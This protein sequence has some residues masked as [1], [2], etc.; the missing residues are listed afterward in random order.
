MASANEKQIE[1]SSQINA[2]Q[3]IM[4]DIENEG[5][6]IKLSRTKMNDKKCKY[7]SRMK[8]LKSYLIKKTEKQTKKVICCFNI[9]RR[10]QR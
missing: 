5:S 9:C 10:F 7:G 1:K 8:S 2:E 4:F 3:K 6:E